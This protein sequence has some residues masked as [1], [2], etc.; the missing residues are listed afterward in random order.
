LNCAIEKSGASAC[1]VKYKAWQCTPESLAFRRLWKKN[2]EFKA[3]L[4]D[5]VRH[6]LKTKTSINQYKS[7][8]DIF[9]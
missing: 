7:S 1:K 3:S 8:K 6:R 5:I 4:G 2:G 9:L